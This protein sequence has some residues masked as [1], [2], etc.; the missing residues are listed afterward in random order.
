[1]LTLKQTFDKSRVIKT[2]LLTID[3]RIYRVYKNVFK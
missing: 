1:M 2:I 3:Y